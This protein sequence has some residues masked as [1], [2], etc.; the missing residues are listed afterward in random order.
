[1]STFTLPSVKTPYGLERSSANFR[2]QAPSAPLASYLEIEILLANAY[3]TKAHFWYEPVNI[4]ESAFSIGQK[5]TQISSS[6]E[7]TTALLPISSALSEVPLNS[8]L[9]N[10]TV[11]VRRGWSTRLVSRLASHTIPFAGAPLETSVSLENVGD[12]AIAKTAPILTSNVL[13]AGDR[14]STGLAQPIRSSTLSRLLRR[15]AGVPVHLVRINALAL[16]RFDFDRDVIRRTRFSQ[17]SDQRASSRVRAPT[18]ARF[19]RRLEQERGSRF[20]AAPGR[21]SDLL[22]LGFVAVYLKSAGVRAQL[23]ANSLARLPRNRKEIPFIRFRIKVVKVLSSARPERLGVRVSFK[24]RVAR[25]NRT[26]ILSGEN[27]RLSLYTYSSRLERGRA[28]AITR[29]GTRGVRVWFCYH[30]SFAKRFRPTLLAFVRS[31][32]RLA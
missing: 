26:K 14:W 17:V 12:F 32:C 27:G 7:Q 8:D 19:L 16:A 28:Q 9:S 11:S 31:G 18:S 1:M 2:R 10:Y 13:R 15:L 3:P 5:A 22:R 30:P 23:L 6:T 4:R 20:A 21:L 25:W 24:G 29:K